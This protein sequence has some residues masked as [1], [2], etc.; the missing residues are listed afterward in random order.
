MKSSQYFIINLWSYRLEIFDCIMYEKL[1]PIYYCTAT[2]IYFNIYW[3]VYN[4]V[5]MRCLY[6]CI[7]SGLCHYIIRTVCIHTIHFIQILSPTKYLSFDCCH[8]MGSGKNELNH[9]LMS[10]NWLFM[11]QNE[12]WTPLT[13]DQGWLVV[14][15]AVYWG[16]GHEY[17]LVAPP[18]SWPQS[19]DTGS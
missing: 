3:Y 17:P 9:L 7:V 19:R 11:S 1:R 16:H 15:V 4:Y 8:K 14:L 2:V 13:S 5:C 12:Q 10:I 6:V 18:D